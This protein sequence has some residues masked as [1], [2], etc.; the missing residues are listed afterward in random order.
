MSNIKVKCKILGANHVIIRIT[1]KNEYN[2]FLQSYETIVVH[3]K[4]S[5]V[6]TLDE[7]KWDYSKTTTKYVAKFLNESPAEIRLN[8]KN[9]IYKLGNLNKQ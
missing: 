1:T 6:I 3:I 7:N 9:G 8:I 2:V 5:G 4:N